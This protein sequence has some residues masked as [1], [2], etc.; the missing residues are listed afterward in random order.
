MLSVE[1]FEKHLDLW[2][3]HNQNISLNVRKVALVIASYYGMFTYSAK[4]SEEDIEMITYGKILRG[5]NHFILTDNMKYG[6]LA[7][8][9]GLSGNINIIE[10]ICC[11]V[12][13]NL[14]I[15]SCRYDTACEAC[16]TTGNNSVRDVILSKC[17]PSFQ[18]RHRIGK[19]VGFYRE[20][21][22]CDIFTSMFIMLFIILT[23]NMIF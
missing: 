4:C 14:C 1:T 5:D 6:N 8:C 16:I 11:T 10:K 22:K 3:T 20:A 23:M 17:T 7:L 18:A 15:E 13:N 19:T 21:T 2:D 9:A 12:D